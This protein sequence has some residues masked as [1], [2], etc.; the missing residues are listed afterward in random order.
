[1]LAANR[2]LA[3]PGPFELCHVTFDASH[4]HWRERG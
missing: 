3:R 4:A 2:Y 1:M